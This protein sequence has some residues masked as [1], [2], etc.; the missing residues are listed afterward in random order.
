MALCILT[1]RSK[2]MDKSI[3]TDNLLDFLKTVNTDLEHHERIAKLV[4]ISEEWTVENAILTPSMK[5]KR[6]SIDEIYQAQYQTWM[7]S[8]EL[9]I[10]TE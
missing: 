2:N 4:L 6:K 9:V 10:F 7:N 8:S 5:I 3:I 1:E